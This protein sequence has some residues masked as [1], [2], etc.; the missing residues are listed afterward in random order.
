M[1]SKFTLGLLSS[2]FVL[3]MASSNAQAQSAFA[4][5]YGQIIHAC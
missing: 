3:G 2:L 5:F 1:K 4:D